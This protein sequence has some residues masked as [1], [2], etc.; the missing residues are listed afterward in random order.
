MAAY[1]FSHEDYW[2][3]ASRRMREELGVTDPRLE[4]GTF[5]RKNQFSAKTGLAID[6]CL[7]SQRT[8]KPRADEF[9]TGLYAFWI[10]LPA[11]L[12]SPFRC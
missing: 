11:T 8:E 1:L 7:A 3:G 2:A 5:R 6:E 9:R 12:P 10:V 4:L